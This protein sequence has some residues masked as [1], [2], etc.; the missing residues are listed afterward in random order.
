MEKCECQ[1]G[2]GQLP[3]LAEVGLTLAALLGCGVATDLC[4]EL[5]VAWLN[6][7]AW[8]H[9]QPWLFAGCQGLEGDFVPC[10]PSTIRIFSV[11]LSSSYAQL[12]RNSKGRFFLRFWFL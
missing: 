1:G 3:T 2:G 9:S 11:F 6:S 10:L 4:G 5:V 7:V 8:A 12:L